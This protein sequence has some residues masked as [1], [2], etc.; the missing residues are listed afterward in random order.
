M[1]VDY[2]GKKVNRLTALE[3]VNKGNYNS[4]KNRW[5]W[6]CICDCGNIVYLRTN[7]ITNGKRKSC[8]CYMKDFNAENNTLP[9]NEGPKR[10]IM[11]QYNAHA[12]RRNLEFNLSESEFFNLIESNCYYCGLSSQNSNSGKHTKGFKYSGIDRVDNSIGYSTD[13]CVPC[14]HKC[15]DSKKNY[16]VDEWMQWLDRL[17]KFQS[18]KG[19]FNDYPEGEY[20]QVDGNGEGPGLGS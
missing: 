19:T 7:E 20:I 9:N 15:N 3:Y 6:K 18:S 12:K 1:K 10:E 16:T 8:G 4:G 13:N 17:Y 5:M 14:C 2:T 11:R